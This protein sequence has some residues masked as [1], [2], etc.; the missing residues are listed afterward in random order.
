MD[1]AEAGASSIIDLRLGESGADYTKG[2]TVLL[3]CA[4]QI[5]K[6]TVQRLLELASQDEARDD[7]RFRN[8]RISD[9]R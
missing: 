3:Y 2:H 7:G 5:C 9:A 6:D 1:A 4:F 8:S